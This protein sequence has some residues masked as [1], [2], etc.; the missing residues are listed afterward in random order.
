MI[1]RYSRPAM[2][3]VWSDAHR[4]GLWLEV[5]LAMTAAREE[6]GSVPAGTARRI[7]EHAR[8]DERRMQEIEAETRHDVIAFLRMLAESIGDDARHVHTG[9][10]SSDLVDTALAC[11]IVEAGGLLHAGLV[12]LRAQA[13]ALAGQSV[14]PRSR[15]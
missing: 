15:G 12:A 14:N 1:E 4:L 6:A 10:T 2:N 8:I 5:E 13:H 7:R 3:R 9:M 11:Q